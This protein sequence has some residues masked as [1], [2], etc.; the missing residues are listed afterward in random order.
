MAS[1]MDLIDVKVHYLSHG[2]DRCVYLELDRPELENFGY[3]GFC[4]KIQHEIPAFSVVD[5][6]ALRVMYKDDQGDWIDVN[7]KTFHK[8]IR[9]AHQDSKSGPNPRV[10]VKVFEGSPFV[11]NIKNVT[12]SISHD[13]HSSVRRELAQDYQSTRTSSSSSKKVYLSP[14]Q[15]DIRAK[16]EEYIQQKYEYDELC[17]KVQSLQD[18]FCVN[19][20]ENKTIPVCGNCHLRVSRGHNKRNCKSNTCEDIRTCG[21]IAAHESA[22]TELKELVSARDKAEGLMKKIKS[23]LDAKIKMEQNVNQ[24]FEAQIK[25]HLINSNPDKYLFDG[26]KERSRVL[27]ADMAILRKHYK[28]EMPNNAEMESKKWENIIKT[29]EERKIP[30]SVK[31]PVQE[32]LKH[33]SIYD[34]RF[35]TTAATV[36]STTSGMTVS[37]PGSVPTVDTFSPGINPMM[38]HAGYYPW[39]YQGAYVP[40]QMHGFNMPVQPN[41]QSSE[42]AYS[43]TQS[44]S[45]GEKDDFNVWENI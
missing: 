5:T 4:H 16:E 34:V 21:N 28:G 3:A 35:P 36:S 41:P 8:L 39:M 12:E 18:T 19:V 37:S 38:I 27:M 45:S 25:P 26:F 11:G 1:Y 24:T 32:L 29:F 20:T 42:C 14:I 15:L 23:E 6:K 2:V 43:S 31:N 9:A 30:K 22:K 33:N 13:P 10:N 17:A 40:Q 7:D 44:D